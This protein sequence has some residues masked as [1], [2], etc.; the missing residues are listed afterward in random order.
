MTFCTNNSSD[1]SCAGRPRMPDGFIR[2]AAI[3]K[4]DDGSWIQ[5]HAASLS[6]MLHS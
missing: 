6:C 4:A 2:A 5:V 3:S 1:N